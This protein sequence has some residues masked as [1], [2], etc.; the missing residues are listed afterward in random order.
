VVGDGEAG[1]QGDD[2]AAS[3]MSD[4]RGQRGGAVGGAPPYTEEKFVRKTVA[5][6][7]RIEEERI[8]LTEKEGVTE[9]DGVVL[10]RIGGL[11]FVCVLIGATTTLVV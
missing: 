7:H 4:G 11:F 10:L 6:R 3:A 2:G 1:R 9:E 8:G 5:L